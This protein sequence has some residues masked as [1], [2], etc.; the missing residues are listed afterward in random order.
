MSRGALYQHRI[1]L[2]LIDARPEPRTLFGENVNS[3]RQLHT[4]QD[5]GVWCAEHLA[6][7][8]ADYH[9]QLVTTGESLVLQLQLERAQ[10]IEAGKLNAEIVMRAAAFLPDG[11]PIW[12]GLVTARASRFG[13]T[14]NLEGYYQAL[15]AA[16]RDAARDLLN[17][18][19]LVFAASRSGEVPVPAPAM[20]RS[21]G[22]VVQVPAA[23]AG[24]IVVRAPAA[25]P[26]SAAA[27]ATQE[28]PSPAPSESAPGR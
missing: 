10:V 2:V 5:V 13:R 21:Q 25:E 11:R 15:S 12:Q 9:L 22:Q 23:A 18:E 28:Q 27:P 8:L 7:T 20:A 26:A 24:A 1:K 3:G 14:H 19:A 17:D 4:D 16:V 6:G